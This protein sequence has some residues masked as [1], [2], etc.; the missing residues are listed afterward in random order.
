M[1]LLEDRL[2]VTVCQFPVR[3]IQDSDFKESCT[4][5]IALLRNR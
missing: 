5:V 4:T 1:G 3:G 2:Q